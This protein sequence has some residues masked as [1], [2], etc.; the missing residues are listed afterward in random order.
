[1]KKTTLLKSIAVGLFAILMVFNITMTNKHNS[2]GF[3][4]SLTG[5]KSMAYASGEDDSNVEY[6]VTCTYNGKGYLIGYSCTKTTNG[7]ECD[8]PEEE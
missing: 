4:L 8:C 1:M 5:L 6:E 2:T 3:D 7:F